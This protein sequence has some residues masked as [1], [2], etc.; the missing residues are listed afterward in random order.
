M[1]EEE[2]GLLE[3][4][5]EAS[6]RTGEL[7][8]VHKWSDTPDIFLAGFVHHFDGRRAILHL[9]DT[10][11]RPD[12]EDT[13]PLA[14]IQ[15][16]HRGSAYLT[17][18]AHLHGQTE[19]VAKMA[20]HLSR[21]P[22]TIAAALAR[23]QATEAVATLELEGGEAMVGIVRSL[24][25]EHALIEVLIDGMPDGMYTLRLALLRAVRTGS[26]RERGEQIL[27]RAANGLEP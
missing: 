12:G 25:E 4:Q 21:A 3:R 20:G 24:D 23:A 6:W 7:I 9:V 17:G 5:L 1:R 19:P 26:D 11:G 22:R 18:L 2:K 10:C 14:E 15:A 27:Y 16:V 13:V 8:A